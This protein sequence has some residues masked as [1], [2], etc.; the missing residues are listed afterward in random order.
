MSEENTDVNALG[1]I[2]VVVAKIA[3]KTVDNLAD[4]K[5]SKV[6]MMK[7]LPDII[8]AINAAMDAREAIDEV[9]AGISPEERAKLVVLLKEGFDTENDKLEEQV[10]VLLD[11]VLSFIDAAMDITKAIKTIKG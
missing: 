9:K 2:V 11:A 1:A 5:I 3:G 7:Y 6:E 4:G 8:P 10:E